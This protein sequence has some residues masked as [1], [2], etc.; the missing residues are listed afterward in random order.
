MILYAMCCAVC[1]K[2]AAEAKVDPILLC[3]IKLT[4]GDA[5]GG[6]VTKRGESVQV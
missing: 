3:D 6:K 5:V 2:C 1:I 4:G